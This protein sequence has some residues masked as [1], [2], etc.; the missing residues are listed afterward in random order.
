MRLQRRKEQ[1]LPRLLP[2]RER[3]KA[4]LLKQAGVRRG[5]I[6]GLRWGPIDRDN[7]LASYVSRG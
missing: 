2:Y 7:G 5:V 4:I 3:L 1:D 6:L